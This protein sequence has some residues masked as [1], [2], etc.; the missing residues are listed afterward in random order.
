[1]KLHKREL[2]VNQKRADICL[3]IFEAFREADLTYG[4]SISILSEV[5]AHL[6][7]YMIRDERHPNA[8]DKP[9]GLE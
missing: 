7:K 6:S 9:G 8:F 3:M 1:M 4:E 5:L 2:M